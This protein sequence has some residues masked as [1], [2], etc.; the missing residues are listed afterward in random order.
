MH[1]PSA[2]P[3]ALHVGSN[4]SGARDGTKYGASRTSTRNF[5][6]HHMQRLSMAAAIG[7]ARGILEQLGREKH[8]L[9]SATAAA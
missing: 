7:N 1:T 8:A 2:R 5:F 9:L 4:G 3:H 6:V